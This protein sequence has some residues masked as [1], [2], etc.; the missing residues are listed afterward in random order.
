VNSAFRLSNLRPK[1]SQ[2]PINPQHLIDQAKTLEETPA[3]RPRGVNLRRAI[4][5]AYYAIFHTVLSAAADAVLPADKRATEEYK[6][7]Y[8]SIDHSRLRELC[9]EIQKS[10][11][12]GSAIRDFAAIVLD[13][14]EKRHSADY[15]PL[16]VV[17]RSDTKLTIVAAESAISKFN[18]APEG[19]RVQFLLQLL[20]PSTRR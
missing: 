10:N 3:G 17:N 19:E 5:A 13:L 9:N 18:G 12:F 8:R 7:I 16:F 14:R 4:S 11:I 15:D 2:L 1:A 6:R 20:S